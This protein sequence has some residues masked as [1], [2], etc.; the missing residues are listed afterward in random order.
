MKSIFYPFFLCLILASTSNLSAQELSIKYL[1]TYA[2]GGSAAAE[3]VAYDAASQQ[4]FF[5]NAG[6]NTI[7]VVSISD[8][9]TP[10]LVQQIAVPDGDLTS[11]AVHNGVV[12]AA[13]ANEDTQAP[14]LVRFFDT[15]GNTLSEVT[16]GALPDMVIFTPD[17]SKLLVA[18]EGEPNDDYTID[19]EGTISIIDLNNGVENAT[20]VH[21]DFSAFVGQSL[22]PSIR[23][24]GNNGQATLTQDIEPEYIAIAP[25]GKTAYVVCQENNA[26]AIVDIESATVI[27]LKGLGY[28]DHSLPGNKM[29]ASDRDDVINL[30]SYP[31]LGMYLPDAIAAYQAVGSTY[32]VTANEGDARDYDGYS[33]EERVKDLI[34]DPIAYPNAAELQEDEV[35]GRLKTTSSQGDFD[36]D[37]DYD[38]IYTYGARSFSIWDKSGQLV[39]DSKDD[40]ETII[41]EKLPALFNSEGAEDSFDGRSDDK[42]PE[43]EAI[44][45][46]E[47]NG[48]TYAFIGLERAGGFMIYNITVPHAA[49]FVDYVNN[50]EF[51][52]APESII[53][54]DATKSPTGSELIVS[55]N[56]ESGTISIF[57]LYNC[58]SPGKGSGSIAVNDQD[59]TISWAYTG[60]EAYVFQYR[61]AGASQW[62]EIL[63]ETN[64]VT[65]EGLAAGG[66]YQFR[67]AA[68]CGERM[69]TFSNFPA[70]RVPYSFSG[71]A[72]ADNNSGVTA[73]LYPNPATDLV[74]VQLQN[75][76]DGP[77]TVMIRDVL[78]RIV[79]SHSFELSTGHNQLELNVQDLLEGHY[80][81]DINTVDNSTTITFHKK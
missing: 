40:F 81:L 62:Q 71:L 43:P 46:V 76:T 9:A 79:K 66:L 47:K 58:K 15:D 1:S 37:G 64:S 45:I 29:D 78:G 14:G 75:Q 44:A 80:V 38:Q 13:I 41:A 67:V 69:T 63:V 6:N 57:E 2:T 49:Y 28:K 73:N 60:S 10:T 77:A 7:D 24:F 59:L 68:M 55:A 17:G 8:P 48:Q 27:A 51:D 53:Y 4:L 56:E 3:I 16:V 31:V 26:I 23:I 11:V 21:A 72:G 30:Q 42:G 33:E 54:I 12:A 5:T 36:G 25:D 65:L 20:A 74:N 35:M 18:N 52:V 70:F 34:L 22:D 50:Y 32:L 19:P 39:F 61:E